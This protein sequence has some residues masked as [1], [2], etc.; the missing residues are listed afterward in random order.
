MGIGTLG[1][2]LFHSQLKNF[3]KK[4]GDKVESPLNGYVIDLVRDDLLIEVQT[5]NFSSIKKKLR[6]LISDYKI[7]LVYPVILNKWIS[8]GSGKRLSPKHCGINNVFDELIYIPKLVKNPNLLVE[9]VVVE[10]EE[11]REK[12]RVSWRKSW[13]VKERKLV[14]VKEKKTFR[15]ARDFLKQLPGNISRPFTNNSLAKKMNESVKLVRKMTYCLRKMGVLEVVGKD[16][17]KMLFSF[18]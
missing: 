16:G 12:K 3:Y 15:N 7:L 9:A 1:E 8:Y 17:S 5:Q 13:V 18:C 2:S 6:D 14:S 10:V 4:P 11:L